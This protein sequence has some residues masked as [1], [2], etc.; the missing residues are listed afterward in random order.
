[1][2]RLTEQNPQAPSIQSHASTDHSRIGLL[3]SLLSG[4]DPVLLPEL[5][6]AAPLGHSFASVRSALGVSR[7]E[8]I[9][10]LEEL[11][12]QGLLKRQLHN[13]I[14]LCPSCDGRQINFRET[15]P[16]CSSID[17]ELEPL[18]IH[19]A[20]AHCALESDY[21]NGLDLVCPKCRLHLERL[22]QD[23]DQPHETYV[24][25]REG[26]LFEDPCVD[27]QCMDCGCVSQAGDLKVAQVFAYRPTPKA[28]RAVKL[29]RLDAQSADSPSNATFLP[30]SEEALESAVERELGRLRDRGGNFALATLSFRDGDREY[31]VLREWSNDAVND[32]TWILMTCLRG[33]DMVAKVDPSRLGILLAGADERSCR[34]VRA[35][36]LNALREL[37]FRSTTG[38]ELTPALHFETWPAATAG[39]EEVMACVRGERQ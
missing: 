39:V 37:E 1:M 22:G 30:D 16:S 33:Q 8:D 9:E 12:D 19:F 38:R 7:G 5:D 24:C 11:A 13:R 15:C 27:G 26:H 36:I 10:A 3:S 14:H 18:I 6:A 17:L 2:Q 35:R 32:M 4:T 23:F 29:G 28:L 34:V 20:C 25:G 31:P 21:R